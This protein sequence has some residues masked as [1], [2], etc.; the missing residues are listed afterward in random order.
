MGLNEG[1]EEALVGGR[2]LESHSV[3]TPHDAAKIRDVFAVPVGL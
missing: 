2:E 3:G 1:R